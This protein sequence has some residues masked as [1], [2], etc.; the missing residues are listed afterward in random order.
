MNYVKANYTAMKNFFNGTDWMI[1]KEQR[2]MQQQNYSF[3]T[4][5]E[6]V[7]K[8]YIPFYKGKKVV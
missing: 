7:I 8:E 2:Q 4:I 3:P 1:M 6:Q 5:C